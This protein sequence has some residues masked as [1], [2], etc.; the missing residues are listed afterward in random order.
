VSAAWDFDRINSAYNIYLRR[1]RKLPPTGLAPKEEAEALLR[2]VTCEH[3]AWKA[4]VSIDPLLPSSLLPGGYRGRK[5]WKA[6]LEARTAVQ[7]RVLALQG[8][9]PSSGHP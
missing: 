8:S 4:A 9:L 5:A 2:W 3:E 7:A 6:H 1:S